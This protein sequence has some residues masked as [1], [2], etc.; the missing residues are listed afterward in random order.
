MD[1]DQIEYRLFAHYS[2]AAGLITAIQNG[3][4]VHQAT[5]AIIYNVP[6]AEVTE[7]QRTKAKTVNFSLIYGQ[8]D[9]ASARSLKM[10]ISDAR[11]FKANYFAQIPE[12]GPFITTVQRV[13]K[14]R[15]YIKNFYG[16]RR[17]LKVD[18]AY[19]APNALIQGCA[20]DYIKDKLVDIYRFLKSSKYKTRMI[21]VVHDEIVFEIHNTEH[22]L[23]PKL[24]YLLSEFNVFRV[25]I[26]AG[27]DFG[28]TSWGEKEAPAE[29]GFEEVPYD[30]IKNYNVFDGSVFDL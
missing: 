19:K 26:T 9:E 29:V 11:T 6:Y 1:L 14:T 3:H 10:A 23:V 8:G 16:R 21:N 13:T 5:A 15:G 4:D 17:R 30:A 22:Y 28:N 12:A 7:E 24:R 18:E 2:K 25:P 20:A 27:V